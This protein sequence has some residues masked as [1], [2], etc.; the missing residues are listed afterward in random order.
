MSTEEELILREVKR[1]NKCCFICNERGPT[2]VDMDHS[3]FVCTF[4]SGL[5]REFS[6]KVKSTSMSKFSLTEVKQLRSLSNAQAK[7]FWLK[8]F[9]GANPRPGETEVIR[10]FIR[11]T[12][13]ENK[14]ADIGEEE[15]DRSSAVKYQDE[16]DS[17]PLPP[18]P[19]KSTAAAK[20]Q[21]PTKLMIKLSKRHT[22]DDEDDFG[23]FMS[24]SQQKPAAVLDDFDDF[25]SAPA[26]VPKQNIEDLFGFTPPTNPFTRAKQTGT[27]L[28]AYPGRN[29]FAQF[30]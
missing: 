6:F 30:N 26:P 5:L 1:E 13:V 18:K 19:I 17:P 2:Y 10:Q 11:H 9:R 24:S 12:F 20:Q 15:D 21:Q 4:C 28:P 8:R 27:T 3:T 16:W 22:E 14:W 29:L 25:V 23:N 7:P